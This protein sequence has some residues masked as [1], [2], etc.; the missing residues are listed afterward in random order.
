MRGG[1]PQQG[2]SPELSALIALHGTHLLTI[3][4]HWFLFMLVSRHQP[5]SLFLPPPQSMD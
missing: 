2:C 3:S 1:T 5:Q 4:A